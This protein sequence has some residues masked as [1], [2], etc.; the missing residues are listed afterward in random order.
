MYSQIKKAGFIIALILFYFLGIRE[1]RG[2]VHDLH[3]GTILPEDY[4]KVQEEINFTA[5]S[6]VSF[7]FYEEAEVIHK[8]WDYKI[9]F[10]MFFLFGCI[11]LIT[12]GSRSN[13]YMYLIGIHFIGG[14]LSFVGLLLALTL[15]IKFLIIP[16]ILSNYLVPLCSLGLVALSYIQKREALK[17]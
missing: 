11:G 8:K 2:V 14:I 17:E 4:G 7:S 15:S 6:S 12:L 1:L 9:P 3:L 5:Q 10:G 13:S 16:D